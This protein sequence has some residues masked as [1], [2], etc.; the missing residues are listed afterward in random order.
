M[1]DARALARGAAGRRGRVTAIDLLTLAAAAAI[2]LMLFL[3]QQRVR[4]LLANEDDVI[5]D[6]EDLER[7][8]EAHRAAATTDADGDGHGEYAPL[9]DV[10]GPR[11]ADFERIEG[12]DVWRRGGYYFTVLLP[13]RSY[14]P[15]PAVSPE[16]WPEWAEIAALLV[17]WPARPGKSGMRAYA[18]WP[19]GVLLQHAID[20]FPYGIEPPF[21]RVPLIHRDASGARAAERYDREDW[22]PPVFT[23][24][25]RDKR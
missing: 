17:A 20:G 3:P 13:D 4:G 5:E 1:S 25:R 19:G 8:E 15:V 23:P 11:A 6:L 7:R 9:G 12:T 22:R 21:P 2:A 10:L 24:R 16:V 18:R 14:L